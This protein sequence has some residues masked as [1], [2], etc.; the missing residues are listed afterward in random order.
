MHKM[1]ALASLEI[2]ILGAGKVFADMNIDVPAYVFYPLWIMCGI[3]PIILCWSEIRTLFAIDR[4]RGVMDF[5]W[6]AKEIVKMLLLG[7][8][9]VILLAL[10]VE[11]VKDVILTAV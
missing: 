1:S 4:F 5:L 8:G 11:Y 2:F 10:T 3:M 6:I 7:F 9:A